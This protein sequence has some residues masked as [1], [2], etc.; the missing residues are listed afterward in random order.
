MAIAAPLLIGLAILATYIGYLILQRTMDAWLRPVLQWIFA[1]R[2]SMWK[3]LLLWPVREIGRGVKAV[4]RY[5]GAILGGAFYLAGAALARFL[6]AVGWTE[7]L[8][9]LGMTRAFRAVVDGLI[10]LREVAVPK[11]I[12]AQ[13]KPVADKANTAFALA[14]AAATTLTGISTEFGSGLRS[15]PWGAPIGIVPR[16][17][18]FW[19]A[20]EHLWDQV[21]KHIVPRLDLIQYTTL[22]RVAGD[23]ADIFDDLYRTGRNSLP[24]I[25]KRI[26]T[27]E[28]ALGGLFA[29][30]IA[31]LE[32]LLVSVAGL[33]MLVRVLERVAPQLFCRN[34]T[35]VAR[36]LCA[37]DFGNLD[38]LLELLTAAVIIANF[39]TYVRIL[40][41]ATATT[42][43]GIK[44]LLEV[45]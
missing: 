45:T 3:R 38:A 16:V 2:T 9:T 30:P 24:N 6:T 5:V 35:K 4:M 40:Q 23:V 22:P 34:T 36:Q 33:A 44:E 41:G 42:A 31:W 13:V 37:A 29:N 8:L 28:D 32:A 26:A 7:D 17:A 39:E 43:S 1:P 18:A 15:L 12:T 27:I 11:L 20:F 21:F 14:S 19:N 10:Y 25:R